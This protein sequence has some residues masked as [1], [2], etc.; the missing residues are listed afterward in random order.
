[1][2]ILFLIEMGIVAVIVVV[3]FFVFF[4]NTAAIKALSNIFP[5]ADSLKVKSV[6]DTYSGEDG[7]IVAAELSLIEENP[8]FSS[9]FQNILRNTNAYISRNRGASDFDILKELAELKSESKEESIE[10]NIALPLYIGLLCT[11]TGVIIGLIQIVMNGVTGEAIQSF[12]GG[13]LI[14]IV[15]SAVGLLLTVIGNQRLKESKLV[16]DDKQYDYFSF[17]RTHIIPTLSKDPEQPID[18]LRSNLAAFNDNFARYQS[19]MN[20]SLTDTLRL[21]K[22]LKGVFGQI[23]SIEQGLNGMG[24]FLQVNDSLI[25]RQVAY[26]DSYAKKAE[27]FS[28]KLG[29]HFGQVNRKME[30]LVHDNVQALERST[31]AAYVKMD[32]YL[33]SIGNTDNKEF[34]EALNKDLNKI[35]GDIELLQNKSLEVNT[36]LLEH[37]G[38]ES[39]SVT[40]LGDKMN[41]IDQRVS[42]ISNAQNS[43]FMN[44]GAFQFFTYAGVAAFLTGIGCGVVY[45]INTFGG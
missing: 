3:Q 35:R 19:H 11:F 32:Q 16:R 41:Q 28:E 8:G 9:T 39:H 20:D 17:L 18:T 36:R 25:E 4:R 1:M 26:I 42:I 27:E 37:L 12:L 7:S 30:T 34:A 40:E 38:K 10:T 45:L 14:G 31:Q 29:T 24:N 33:A 23:R 44:S 15:G 13:I 22:E 5:R 2:D 43:S 6:P 21:F